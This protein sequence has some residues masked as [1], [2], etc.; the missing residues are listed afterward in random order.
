MSGG[1]FDK[2]KIKSLPSGQEGF[3]LVELTVVII[4]L[5]IILSIG[6][7]SYVNISRNMN[8]SGAAK[9]VEEALNRAKTAARQENV[10]YRLTFYPNGGGSTANSYE[11]EHYVET[12]PGTWTMT[13]VNQSVSGEQVTE[14][15]GHWYIKIPHGVTVGGE[16]AVTIEFT[17][18]GAQMTINPA[19]V[20]LQYGGATRSVSINTE[21]SVS[22]D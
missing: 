19:T 13:P 4:I 14:S 8:I 15:S 7:L 21:G 12:S 20:V 9:Q 6:T 11:F 22:V 17:P 18:Q 16:N 5:G 1:I 10:K 2:R 3:T